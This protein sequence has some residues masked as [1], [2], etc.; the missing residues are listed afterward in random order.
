METTERL[1]QQKIVDKIVELQMQ[2]A[3]PVNITIGKEIEG[4]RQIIFEY[5]MID[6]YAV[7]WLI[8]KSVQCI[9]KLPSEALMAI[10]D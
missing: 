10:H 9:T 2:H 1:A 5:E 6:Y 4:L 8:N 7:Q 3:L